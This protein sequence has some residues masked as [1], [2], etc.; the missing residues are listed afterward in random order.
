MKTVSDT[1][2]TN[3]LDAILDEAQR[4]LTVI[5]R[6]GRTAPS[7]CRAGNTSA[8]VRRT[9]MRFWI[10]GTNRGEAAETG[11]TEDRLAEL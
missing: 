11:L 9:S 6:Q 5:R 8:F 2:A 4:E 1:E 10:S 7:F 3:R